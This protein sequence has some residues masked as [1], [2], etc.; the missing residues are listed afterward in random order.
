[1]LIRPVFVVELFLGGR[2]T[3]SQGRPGLLQSGIR[4]IC[5]GFG[6]MYKL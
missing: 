5:H 6:T 2:C 3:F 4:H 1:M